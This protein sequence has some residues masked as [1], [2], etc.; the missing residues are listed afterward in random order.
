MICETCG[1][2]IRDDAAFCPFCGTRVPDGPVYDDY[3]YEAFISYRH[4]E[5]DTKVAVRLQRSLEGYRLPR[6]IKRASDGATR[7][8]KL[9]RDQDELPTSQSLGDQIESALKRSRRLVVICTPQTRESRW[10]MRE[11]ELYASFHG[12]DAI[13]IALAAGEPDES[14]PPLMLSKLVRTE[15]GEVVRIEEEPIAAD[16]R[17]SARKQ[18]DLERLRVASSITGCGFDELR[19]RQHARKM[20]VIAAATSIVA[21][22]STAFGSFS[23]WQQRRIEE[24]FRQTQIRESESLAVES[25]ELL[26]QGDRMQAIQ[27]A[28]A[29]LPQSSTSNDR[30][31]VPAA[32]LALER[33]L[34]VYPTQSYW[35]SC[36][37][38]SDVERAYAS[39]EE[40]LQA[41]LKTDGTILV[42]NIKDGLEVCRFDPVAGITA[43]RPESTEE[44]LRE[45]CMFAFCG[46]RIVWW[47]GKLYALFDART[48]EALWAVGHKDLISSDDIIAELANE[49]NW[50]ELNSD[51]VFGMDMV[52]ERLYPSPD[53]K[54]LAIPLCDQDYTDSDGEYIP[55]ETPTIITISTETGETEHVYRLPSRKRD[56]GAG[57]NGETIRMA[58]SPDS[59]SMAVSNYGMLYLI[60]LASGEIKTGD[61]QQSYAYS[62]DFAGD[63]IVA[64]TAESAGVLEDYITP[65]DDG[66]YIDVFDTSLSHLWS[67]IEKPP[68]KADS[69]LTQKPTRAFVAGVTDDSGDL[70][71]A[72]G[73]SVIIYD[74]KTGDVVSRVQTTEPIVACDNLDGALCYVDSGG[75]LCY[76]AA[77][78]SVIAN[79]LDH[80]ALQVPKTERATFTLS[81]RYYLAQWNSATSSYRVFRATMRYDSP[82]WESFD[83]SAI[84]P[85]GN[86]WYWATEP[87]EKGALLIE[88]G[89]KLM[90]ID[91]E[92]LEASWQVPTKSFAEGDLLSVEIINQ[93]I[94]LVS[95]TESEGLRISLLSLDDGT[96]QDSFEPEVESNIVYGLST[97]KRNGT[98]CLLLKQAHIHRMYDLGTHEEVATLSSED[99]GIMADTWYTDDT[100]LAVSKGE[101]RRTLQV[102]S[103]DTGKRVTADIDRVT[104]PGWRVASTAAD[105]LDDG[106]RFAVVDI[107]GTVRLYDTTDWSQTWESAEQYPRAKHLAFSKDGQHIL[108]QDLTGSC[109]LLSAQD[110][111][112]IAVSATK[113][114]PITNSF[115][116]DDDALIAQYTTDGYRPTRGITLVSLDPDCFGPVDD[117]FTGLVFTYAKQR[118]LAFDQSADR[119]VA[120]HH[121]TMD[122][123]IE[124]AKE[125]IKGHELTE[126]ERHLYRID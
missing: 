91:L 118:I 88:S 12:R 31:Y 30:P 47:N 34:Q 123:L 82:G 112:V 80:F 125:T 104:V 79:P 21:V 94:A 59:T 23:L 5:R 121:Y 116:T 90:L 63:A 46:D 24:N 98:T 60:D 25:A 85:I 110:G 124:L 33:A 102:L 84:M 74:H 8:G 108:L 73:Y 35:R 99:G 20:R 62:V 93:S 14:F 72:V 10:V 65:I 50:M 43:L 100:M 11:V 61:L 55:I 117:A 56:N 97:I 27:V 28:L 81:D 126:A 2:K 95:E 83:D 71:M 7:L 13:V 103:L 45:E 3:T 122:E 76:S 38:I 18:F 119:V 39:C 15:D 54:H 67:A 4:L 40:G 101:D 41:F 57:F 53:D 68:K 66:A 64:I 37:S 1:S 75:Y 58:Y 115:Y 89:D 106:S 69:Q 51:L 19:Q 70:I 113:L 26:A 86:F 36:Y 9:F 42:T 87:T 52:N 120:L 49:L 114:P 29:A 16:F 96:L 105:L 48:G 78:S 32:Q 109:M 107:T 44:E 92:T 17:D 6:G 111:S 22:L 77:E